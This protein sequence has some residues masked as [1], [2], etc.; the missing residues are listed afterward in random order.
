VT[1]AG[2]VNLK[3]MTNLKKLTFEDCRNVSDEG[4]KVL[5]D[6]QALEL[7]NLKGTQTT[8]ASVALLSGLKN[9]KELNLQFTQVSDEGI[10][11]LKKALPK[12]K[13]IE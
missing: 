11:R 3:G 13:V 2:L 9:L 8:D 5:V 10:K 12:A 4:L 6:L 1:D 7:L